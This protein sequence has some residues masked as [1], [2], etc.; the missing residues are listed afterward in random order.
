MLRNATFD[1]IVRGTNLGDGSEG[2]D[3]GSTLESV[4]QKLTTTLNLDPEVQ[5][6]IEA[7][8]AQAEEGM[9]RLRELVGGKVIRFYKYVESDRMTY[10]YSIEEPEE[11]IAGTDVET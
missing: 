2:E 7:T 5:A 10:K 6:R 8:F 9:W 3:K 4:I 11:P 1:A